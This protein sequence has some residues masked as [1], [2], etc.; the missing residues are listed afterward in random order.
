[1]DTIKEVFQKISA[2][3]KNDGVFAELLINGSE[4]LQLSVTK[5]SLEK[6]NSSHSV[7]AGFRVVNGTSQGYA[8]TENLSEDSI[9]RTY[10]EALDS[11]KMFKDSGELIPLP[12]AAEKTSEDMDLCFEEDVDIEKKIEVALQLESEA[13]STDKR[14]SS[15]PWN[16]FSDS[17]SWVRILNTEGLDKSF[18]QKYYTGYAYALAK[19]GESSKTGFDMLFARKFSDVDA[20]KV[21]RQSAQEA[22]SRLGAQTL[23]TGNYPVVMD[24]KVAQNLLAYLGGYFSAKSVYEKTSILKDKLGKSIASTKVTLVD[25][26]LNIKCM[27]V[28]PFDSEGFNS[29]KTVLIEN[30]VAKNY[31]TNLEYSQKMNLPHT[32]SAVRSPATG[33]DVGSSNLIVTKGIFSR[34][35]L[36]ARYPKVVFLTEI[37][38]GLHSG[39]KSTTGDFSLPGEGF[40]YE[41]GKCMGPVDQFVFSGNILELLNCVEDLGNE[42]PDKLSSVLTPDLLLKELSFAGA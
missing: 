16:S 21:G 32:A 40:L 5:G 39:F 35:E 22:L 10:R 41:N 13:M 3:A 20:K 7:R 24:G 33:M 4:Q 42:Y 8:W 28:R 11:A 36:L 34:Q 31:L 2:Q 37:S 18:K 19:E 26:P 14:V 12:K 17:L 38:G 9:D 23:A 27:G 1:M 30:G 25:D 6:F 29:K 15:V